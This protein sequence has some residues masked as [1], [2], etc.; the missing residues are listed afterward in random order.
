MRSR[1]YRGEASA[2]VPCRAF[3]TC[4]GGGLHPSPRLRKD[5][6]PL[7]EPQPEAHSSTRSARDWAVRGRYAA[8]IRG[9]TRAKARSRG[10]RETDRCGGDGAAGCRRACGPKPEPRLCLR[11]A[12][13]ATRA[14]AERSVRRSAPA[15]A[16]RGWGHRLRGGSRNRLSRS[17]AGH[18]RA[19]N[20]ESARGR[21]TDSGTGGNSSFRH[22]S[23]AR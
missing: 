20:P 7:E 15:S 21:R 11:L 3:P 9:V 5:T 14:G 13:R 10:L 1:S 17:G 4:S 2:A 16:P 18:P 19:L 12:P 8:A 23:S 6:G 22:T